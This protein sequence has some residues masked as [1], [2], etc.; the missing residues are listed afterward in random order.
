MPVSLRHASS[1][2]FPDPSPDNSIGMRPLSH[3]DVTL[4]MAETSEGHAALA[5]FGTTC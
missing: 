5:D 1:E 2:S 4:T 3:Q